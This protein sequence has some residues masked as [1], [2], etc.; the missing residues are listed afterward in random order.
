MKEAFNN[1]PIRVNFIIFLFYWFAQVL[2]YIGLPIELESVGGN[3]YINLAV[4]ALLELVGSFIASELSLKYEFLVIFKWFINMTII[5]FLFFFLVPNNLLSQNNYIITFFVIDSFAVKLTYDTTWHLIGMYLPNLFT[6]RF[7]GQYLI[8]AVS[9]SRF[10]L[11]FLPYIN[12]LAKSL[13]FH[14]FAIYGVLWLFS[15]LLLRYAEIVHRKTKSQVGG[16]TL[17]EMKSGVVADDRKFNELDSSSRLVIKRENKLKKYVELK[18]TLITEPENEE[19]KN[20]YVT[21]IDSVIGEERR[22][23][24]FEGL[25][26]PEITKVE[27]SKGGSGENM[28]E[29]KNLPMI[30]RKNVSRVLKRRMSTLEVSEIIKNENPIGDVKKQLYGDESP[31][32]K[33]AR[34]DAIHEEN[35]TKDEIKWKF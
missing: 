3:L 7:Y 19:N 4:F 35:E 9:I 18:E 20:G 27:M 6:P 14:P 22:T 12:F 13:G 30:V 17:F 26:L 21:D 32:L 34:K 10:C 8:V 25:K 16:N 11:I 23:L 1:R 33:E 31:M 28:E 29:N 24:V 5:L 2:T 15:R